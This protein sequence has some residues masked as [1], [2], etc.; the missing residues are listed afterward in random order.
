ML[1][2]KIIF[3][4]N[5]FKMVKIKI[6]SKRDIFLDVKGSIEDFY[7]FN[8]NFTN[9]F[10]FEKIISRKDCNNTYYMKIPI[11]LREEINLNLIKDVKCSIKEN[12]IVF[13]VDYV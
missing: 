6:K 10:K 13:C 2:G 1:L 5:F 3:L 12:L 4:T 9:D 11:N 7:F 8:K